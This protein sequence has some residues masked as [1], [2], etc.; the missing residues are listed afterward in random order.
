MPVGSVAIA[1]PCYVSAWNESDAAPPGLNAPIAVED[2]YRGIVDEKGR[3]LL[4]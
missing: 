3:S 4:Q 2:V 1:G